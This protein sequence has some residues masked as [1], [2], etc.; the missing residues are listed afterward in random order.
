MHPPASR[1]VPT[2]PI[3]ADSA[4]LPGSTA[5]PA[6]R[7]RLERNFYAVSESPQG[8]YALIDYVNFKGEGIKKEE[9]YKGQ[10]WGLAQVLLDMQGEPSGAAAAVE[11]GNAAKRVLTRRVAN[12]KPKDESM[13]LRGWSNRAESYKRPL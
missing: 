10:G 8:V 7:A 9:R 1:S 3:R 5:S 12:A 6:E 11:F 13:W 2:L 4:S